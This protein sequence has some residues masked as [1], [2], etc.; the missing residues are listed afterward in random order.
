ML[1]RL[2]TL[3]RAA[4]AGVNL[5]LW[6]ACAAALA[7]VTFSA[8][9]YLKGRGDQAKKDRAAVAAAGLQS[10]VAGLETQGAH[11]TARR[12]ED[13][14]ARRRTAEAAAAVVTNQALRSEDVHEALSPDVVARLGAADRQLCVADPE[15]AGC[16]ADRHAR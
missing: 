4:L 6:L 9:L 11:T 3:A 10:R 5:R 7:A 1:T 14:I 16:A 15:L 12:V 2:L 13:V 8:G